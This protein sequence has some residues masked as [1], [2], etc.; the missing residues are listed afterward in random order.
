MKSILKKVGYLLAGILLLVVI[1]LL[2]VN[3]ELNKILGAST[4][5][6]DASSSISQAEAIHIKNINVLSE[7][8]SHFIPN[9]DVYIEHGLIKAIVD[10]ATTFP[11][12]ITAIDGTDKYLI[13]GLVDSHVHL[14]ESK[15]DLLLYLANGVTY[16]REMMGSPVTLE[17]KESVR[18]NGYGPAMFIASPPVYSESGLKGYYTAWTRK[19]INYANE[20]DAREAI[21]ELHAMGYDA[22][23][24]YGFVNEEMFKSTIRIAEEYDIP[25]VGHIPQIGLSA[26]YESGQ[27]EIAHIEELTKKTMIDFGSSVYSN[28]DKYLDYLSEQ[29]DEIANQLKLNGITVVSTVWLNESIIEQSVNLEAILKTV[30]LEYVNPAIVEGTKVHKLGW[31]PGG[32][33][34]EAPKEV[35]N[36]SDLRKKQ[37]KFWETYVEAVYM[38]TKSLVKYNVPIFA[39]TD[40][41]APLMVPGFSLHREFEALKRAGLTNSQVLYSATVAPNESMKSNSKP[42]ASFPFWK[43]RWS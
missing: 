37:V 1:G 2:W 27:K 6:V 7:D 40:A 18:K 3:S 11:G 14:Q 38:M 16:V 33:T 24:M 26:V 23:K 36:S 42:C 28:P 9:Q 12:S 4:K 39:G 22:I 32:N 41:N 20:K 31:L 8:C 35:R 21:Q 5:L 17:W 25:V 43:K 29:T 30:E 15:N 10:S 34:Y 13:P 19:A